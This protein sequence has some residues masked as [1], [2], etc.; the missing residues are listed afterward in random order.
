MGITSTLTTANAVW[1]KQT[2]E[3]LNPKDPLAGYVLDILRLGL[4]A[5]TTAALLQGASAT[6]QTAAAAAESDWEITAMSPSDS[7]TE[8]IAA[9][10]TANQT[11]GD[12][13]ISLRA[14]AAQL[15]VIADG[16]KRGA[17]A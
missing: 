14:G 16:L 11:P 6:I 1:R 7:L 13:A 15:R 5:S 4:G 8:Y 2:G 17:I 12:L 3:N 10:A 9:E